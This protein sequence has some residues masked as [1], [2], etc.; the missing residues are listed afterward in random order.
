MVSIAGRKE[1]GSF[2]GPLSVSF[3]CCDAEG[4]VLQ[5]RLLLCSASASG[6]LQGV[7]SSSSCYPIKP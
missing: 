6:V 3:E 5:E 7:L 1:A 2:I 4:E